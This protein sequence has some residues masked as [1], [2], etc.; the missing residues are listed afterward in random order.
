LT[1]AADAADPITVNSVTL[2]FQ[3]MAVS[4]GKTVSAQLID[5]ST[6]TNWSGTSAVSCITTSNSCS[7]QFDFTTIP[8]ISAGTSK[9]VK[10]RIDSTDFYNAATAGDG[11]SIY[12]NTASTTATAGSGVDWGDGTTT[13][14]LYLEATAVPLTIY[15][16]SYE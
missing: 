14:L 7:T 9:T 4:T 15:A 13:K 5:P 3:G 2:K 16:G 1:F 11:L 10:V 6:G 8:T 12:V